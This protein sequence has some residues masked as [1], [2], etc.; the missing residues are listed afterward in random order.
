M[1][2]TTK[3]ASFASV[4]AAAI[5][6]I[7][8]N[9]FQYTAPD[10]AT[11]TRLHLTDI[12]RAYPDGRLVLNTG[13]W[14]TV[15][16]KDR[17]TEQLRSTGYSVYS[18]RGVW[19]VMRHPERT[20]V[21]FVDGMELPRDFD[22]ALASGAAESEIKAARTLLRSITKFCAAGIPDGEPLPQPSTGDC[23]F[24]LFDREP[25]R[26]TVGSLGHVERHTEKWPMGADHIREHLREGYM[27][28][29]L[30]LNALRNAGW[31]DFRIALAFDRR[32]TRHQHTDV[33]R[34]V[35]DYIK[36]RLGLAV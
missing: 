7:A 22:A 34:A 29:S 11:V 32:G 2:R 23:W 9:T 12:L 21:P 10:G 6:K 31:T 13:G 17:L 24:C 3:A 35:R 4:E 19:M 1:P 15:T 8:N 36:R 16:T 5:R 33:R 28:G 25:A 27:H 18:D 20:A 30:I 26:Q 14:Q